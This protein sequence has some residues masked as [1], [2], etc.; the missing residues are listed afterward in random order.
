MDRTERFYKIDQLLNDRRVVSAQD[1]ME[2][3]GISLATFK[4][5]LEYMRD[6]L[7]APIEW[8]RDLGG[9]RYVQADPNA[10]AFALPGLWFNAGEAHALLTMQQLLSN[11]EPGLLAGHIK[12]LQA[13]LQALLDSADHSAEEVENRIRIV[14]AAKRPVATDYF[15]IVATATLRRKRLKLRHYSRQT[16]EET[17]RLVSPLQLIFYR[18]NWYLDTWCHLRKG[19]RS[20]SIDAIR[21]AE[22]LDEP[23]KEISRQQLQEVLESG[24]GIFS[25]KAVAWAELRFTPE[26]A[27]WVSDEVWHPEQKG[28]YDSEG[29][30]VLGI[31]YS[32]DRELIM[33]ILKHGAEVEVLAPAKLRKRVTETL[34]AALSCY[35]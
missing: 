8:D 15:E 32:D 2:E 6:R 20:F 3:L 1:L 27:R 10:P 34:Q 14:H 35:A 21:H 13:R 22:I 31:P 18:D 7:N 5:D 28:S 33:D 25:G 24:Y 29:R 17:E 9:Y 16:G 30:Y 12:P 19:I 26:R 23:A 4:R 11:L